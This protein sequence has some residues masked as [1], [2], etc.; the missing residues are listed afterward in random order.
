[1]TYSRRRHTGAWTIS[2]TIANDL[3]AANRTNL[4]WAK[5]QAIDPTCGDDSDADTGAAFGQDNGEFIIFT[6]DRQLAA[7]Q[8]A[9]KMLGTLQEKKAL[10]YFASGMRL[11]GV[12]NRAQLQSTINSA[13][14]VECLALPGRC[15]RTAGLGPAGR[16]QPRISGRAGHV[17]GIF[18][19]G[20]RPRNFQR[21]QDTLFTLGADTG[22]KAL[23]DFNDLAPASCRRR[24]PSPV[25]TFWATT[26]RI[27]RSTASSGASRSHVKD[28]SAKLD[29]PLGLLRRQAVR[30]VHR[31]PT[32]RGN[33]RMR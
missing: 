19:A 26:P 18:R 11:N 31:R 2:R 16:R 24:S 8:T 7:L 20:Q 15:A 13:I 9:V 6:T 28:L 12:N 27:R 32:R 29:Y 3:L 10:I 33:W 30:Q 14:R 4:S 5:A 25:I 23:L 1:M 17:F 21:S 22:G